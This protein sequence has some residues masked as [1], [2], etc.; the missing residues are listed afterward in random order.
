MVF[1]SV[2][3]VASTND[4]NPPGQ[5]VTPQMNPQVC[6][7]TFL[8]VPF[9]GVKPR[10]R[11]KSS[12]PPALAIAVATVVSTLPCVIYVF[13]APLPLF[14][15]SEC[16]GGMQQRH[17]L[18]LFR[19]HSVSA[20]TGSSC[21]IMMIAQTHIQHITLTFFVFVCF[22]L[23]GGTGAKSVRHGSHGR[24][25]RSRHGRSCWICERLYRASDRI[26]L[27]PR[28]RRWS[29]GGRDHNE[30]QHSLQPRQ[31]AD[32]VGVAEQQDW[33]RG[34]ELPRGILMQNKVLRTMLLDVNLIGDSGA[35]S[36][37]QALEH[38]TALVKLDLWDNKIGDK[39]AVSLA[40]ALE[41][42]TVLTT[43]DLGINKITDTGATDRRGVAGQHGGHRVEA[44]RQHRH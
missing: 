27:H 34:R 17:P 37:A 39:G 6:G 43:L 15:F 1:A 19:T 3:A 20:C 5:R 16:L 22:P 44:R 28:R 24:K 41:K 23:P 29:Y 36:I 4:H 32:E 9:L 18:L 14:S 40:R 12:T 42:N 13:L 2:F 11:S 30:R 38:N 8:G 7:E 21:A 35:M 10:E 25:T 26:P 31:C 33:K